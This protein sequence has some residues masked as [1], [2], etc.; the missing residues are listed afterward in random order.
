[1]PI[2]KKYVIVGKQ[3]EQQKPV[4]RIDG[5]TI[6]I[7]ICVL[8]LCATIGNCGE[9][10]EEKPAWPHWDG[11]E[12]ISAYAKRAGLPATKELNVKGERIHLVLIPA[13]K[14][15]MGG[16]EGE[17]GRSSNETQFEATL[18]K[19]FYMSKFEI[20]QAQWQ[21]VMGRNPPKTSG[22]ND[23]VWFVSWDDAQEFSKKAGN[24]V[25]LPSEAQ[26]EWACRAGTKTRFY[27]GNSNEDLS[28]AG[29]FQENSGKLG[30]SGSGV[31]PVGQKQPNAW[32]LYDM[33]G[34]VEEWCSDWYD[35]YPKVSATD[36]TGPAS[37]GSH[38]LRGG[39]WSG[40][41]WACRS[42]KRNKF[43]ETPL[44]SF[45]FRIIMQVVP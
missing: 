7:G 17:E 37:G 8:A 25:K 4:F 27:T 15:T 44:H 33:H 24:G 1:M 20:T 3:Q 39:S 5:N 19:P 26:W 11:K 23:P 35:F 13:G 10:N 36:P 45:G 22:R 41:A 40:L 42:A 34:N 6:G 14:F 16:P 18:T 43:I 32:G 21:A 31:K 30:P 9:K 38:I 2:S 29:W 28:R 12:T